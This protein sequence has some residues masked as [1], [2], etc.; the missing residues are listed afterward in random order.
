[1]RCNDDVL[2]EQSVVERFNVRTTPTGT[3]KVHLSPSLT[4]LRLPYA[5]IV[6]DIDT[7]DFFV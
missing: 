5:T 1:M 7:I 2:V 6:T 4:A 3:P